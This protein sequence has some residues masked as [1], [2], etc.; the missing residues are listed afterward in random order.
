[1]INFHEAIKYF[2][3]ISLILILLVIFLIYKRM[4]SVSVQDSTG[5]NVYNRKFSFSKSGDVGHLTEDMDNYLDNEPIFQKTRLTQYYKK[6][7]S[8]SSA[9]KAVKSQ[10]K[11]KC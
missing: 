3:I 10:K 9:K 8:S 2:K 11:Y 5:C 4:Y 1:M 7:K 6:K